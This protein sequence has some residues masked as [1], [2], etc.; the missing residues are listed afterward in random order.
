HNEA[1]KKKSNKRA[2]V[3]VRSNAAPIPGQWKLFLDHRFAYNGEL[4]PIELYNLAIDQKEQ[5]NRLA[6]PKAKP[7]L[8]FL[9]KEA[10]KAKGDGGSTR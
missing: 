1:S 10:R 4:H 2:V 6:D 5:K 3:A 8:D 9:I 7:A